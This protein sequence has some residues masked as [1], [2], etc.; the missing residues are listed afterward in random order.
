MRK[1][2]VMMFIVLLAGMLIPVSP[3]YS[4]KVPP[5]VSQMVAKAKKSIKTVT[6]AEFK[7]MYDKHE[8]GLL[9]D[10]RD[11]HEY[12]TGHIPG[13]VNISRGT[14][15]FKIWPRVGGPGKPDYNK[16]MMLYCGS[17][18]RCALATKSLMDLGFKN[19]SAINMRLAAWKKAGYPLETKK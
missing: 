19:V 4:A 1:L 14:I 16:K 3:A 13:A 10:V 8:V 2:S 15:E 12:I 11:H 7:A 5:S 17:G 6:M 9:I 18:A